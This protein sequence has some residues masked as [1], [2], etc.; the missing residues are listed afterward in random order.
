MKQDSMP[1]GAGPLLRRYPRFASRNVD[2]VQA[3]MHG[4]RLAYDVHPRDAAALDLVSRG[5][6][7]PGSWI[8][9]IRYGAPGVV[10]TAAD[11]QPPETFWVLFP[12]RGHSELATKTGRLECGPT[13]SA[14]YPSGLRLK[15]SSGENSERVTF[16]VSTATLIRQLEALL[17]DQ[18]LRKLEF[19]PSLDLE[20]AFGRRL[21]RHVSR[22]VADFDDAGPEGI[23]ATMLT[24]YEQLIVTEL[25]LG[26]P[27]NYTD[28]LHRLESRIAPGDVK[29]AIDFIE[30]HV[31]LPLTLTDIARASGVPGRTLL[32]HFKLHCGVSPMRYVRN[33]RLARVR[34]A[35][36]RTDGSRS[37]TEIAMEWGFTHLGRFALEYRE[38]FGESPSETLWRSRA[39]RV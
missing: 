20:T 35:L 10:S 26:Q 7:L 22:V 13:R 17:G 24:M 14:I 23:D 38:Q 32:E 37:V 34:E 33:A 3:L 11:C 16:Q 31:E 30:A 9:Y 36:I 2:E 12:L 25:L 8:G 6:F 21:R 15:H 28:A 18:A 39:R 4:D 29:R 27:S 5:A 19:A 1:T